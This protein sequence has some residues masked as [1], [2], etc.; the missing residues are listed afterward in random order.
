M[1][2]S[3]NNSLIPF[4]YTTRA[5][6]IIMW[7]MKIGYYE[8]LFKFLY[9]CVRV[10]GMMVELVFVEGSLFLCVDFVYQ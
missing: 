9:G 4:A 7:L 3:A 2:S 10:K 8:L 6:I 1:S 5:T